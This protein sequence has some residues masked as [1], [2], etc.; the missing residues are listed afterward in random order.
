MIKK[1]KYNEH[2][3]II[4]KPKIGKGTWIGPFAVIDDSSPLGQLEI[5]KN[6][7][8]S[9]GVHIYTH[10]TAKRCVADKKYNKDGTINR[11]II[12]RKPVKIGDCTFIGANSTVLMGVT[13]GKHCIIGAGSVVTKNIPDF[14]VAT[15]VPAKIVGEI[16]IKNKEVEIRMFK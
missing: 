1:N 11:N 8:I 3:L 7:D 14:S 5:G 16:N 2:S 10:S 13:I 15:G 9:A 4:G 12:E 6:C